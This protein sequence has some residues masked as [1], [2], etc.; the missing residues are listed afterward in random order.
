MLFTLTASILHALIVAVTNSHQVFYGRAGPRMCVL[1]ALELY[2]NYASK[3]MEGQIPY[4]DYLIEYPIFSFPLFLL[5]RLLTA[6][7][8]VY[9]VIF[10]IELLLFNA[11]AVYLVARC[12]E[13][14]EGIER[15]PG[16]LGWYTL[17]FASLCPLLI[18]RFDL[19][20]MAL[21][22]AA[23]SFWFS[24]REVLGGV[25][26]AIGM[27]MK[28]F[29]GV[30][31]GPALIW[32]VSWLGVSRG[33]G[34]SAF[35]LS[36]AASAML[37]FAL[38]GKG[39]FVSL[40]YHL[41]RGLQVWSLYTGILVSIAK[42]RGAAI[43]PT[44]EHGSACLKTPWSSTVAALVFPI[45][46]VSL[47]GVL[48][49]FQRSG[50]REPMR[51]AGAAV[52]AFMIT[53]KVFSPQFMIWLFPFMAVVGGWTGQLVRWLFLLSC[54]LTTVLFPWVHF[55][56]MDAEGWAIGLLNLRNILLLGVL[57][58]LLFG[59]ESRCGGADRRQS[60][61]SRVSSS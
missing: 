60:A 21:A 61:I 39:M 27:F 35:V 10:G 53:G 13:R 16:R 8:A 18:G 4:R 52:L 5:P 29:P 47:L 55:Q 48:W 7:F 41:G 34:M 42:T 6:D 25:A 44:I 24:G 17:F 14:T 36:S 50:M 30:I 26:A 32:E 28:F 59:P 20:P 38:G 46:M 11:A 9:K 58:L 31:A 33:R 51:Y 43:W 23:A 37:W 49:R 22:F 12:V 56:L 45:Q 15:V 19:A 1:N 54:I 2:F 40:W 57:A 3:A